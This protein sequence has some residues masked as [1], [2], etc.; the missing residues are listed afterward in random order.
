MWGGGGGEMPMGTRGG[1]GGCLWTRGAQGLVGGEMQTGACGVGGVG[2]NLFGM[3]GGLKGE[4][5]LWGP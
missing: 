2:E 4:C 3:Y 1:V 5:F